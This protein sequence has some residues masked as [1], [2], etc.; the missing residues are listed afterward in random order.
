MIGSDADYGMMRAYGARGW[1]RFVVIDRSGVIAFHGFPADMELANIR[2][3]LNALAPEGA[4]PRDGTA[5]ENGVCYPQFAFDAMKARR[6]RS[7]RLALDAEGKPSVA[8]YS[9]R[10]G[11]NAIYL[12][13]V[14][15]DGALLD[16]CLTPTDSD[17]Y[18]PDCA[19]DTSGRLWVVWCAKFG[20]AYDV[21]AWH[22]GTDGSGVTTPLTRSAEDAMR[23][24]IA[25]GPGGALTVA[26]YK[27]R[28]MHGVSR[29]RD[30][31][32]RTYAP[33]S[34]TWDEEQAVCPR[35]PEVEDH[36][37]PD[38]AITGQGDSWVVWS[39]D[40]HPGLF[41]SPKDA[42]QPT[43]FA[44]SIGAFSGVSEPVLIGTVGHIRHATDLFPSAAVDASGVL[45]CAWDADD[46]NGPTR[47]IRLARLDGD[48]FGE[49]TD[50]T[51][52][53][54]LCS[55][56]ELSPGKDGTILAT[57]SQRVDGVW[58]G[59]AAVLRDGEVVKETSFNERPADVLYP[60]AA[61]G[62][63]GRIWV[64][65][66]KCGEGGSEI[67]LKEITEALTGTP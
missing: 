14:K 25:A 24:R 15:P 57:W 54:K 27:W 53:G 19:F 66:E 55:T 5:L 64:V 9:N 43:I 8:F 47:V 10:D 49:A 28:S 16:T 46:G 18:A 6:D 32:C 63:D 22:G 2:A 7:P 58:V 33:A 50:L 44:A 20:K 61:Q 34:G 65:Y 3:C 21:Y 12:R 26:Y 11:G 29:D 35:V 38:V 62:A 56:P 23:P 52:R 48:R 45:W 17:C 13:T 31:F 59:K 42:D 40:Y 30:I 1:P 37:D 51:E 36:T 39:Y 67:V 41:P 4:T 60:Q